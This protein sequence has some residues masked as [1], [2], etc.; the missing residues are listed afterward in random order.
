[1]SDQGAYKYKIPKLTILQTDVSEP[2]LLFRRMALDKLDTRK[3]FGKAENNYV[4]FRMKYERPDQDFTGLRK[5]ILAIRGKT[6]M[7][8]RFEGIVGIDIT[9]WKGHESE[10]YFQILEKYLYDNGDKWWLVFICS[11]YSDQEFNELRYNCVNY[12]VIERE[13]AYVY[14]TDYLNR[15]IKDALSSFSATAEEAGIRHLGDILRSEK[16]RNFRSIQMIR[17][18]VYELCTS[19]DSTENKMITDQMIRNYLTDPL[20]ILNIL[21]GGSFHGGAGGTRDVV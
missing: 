5:L 12:F 8:S 14:E 20:C 1:M 17:R 7:R 10:E 2:E 15:C 6:G 4:F 3:Q 13:Q 21:T 18:I 19:I 16:M 11:N 9:A